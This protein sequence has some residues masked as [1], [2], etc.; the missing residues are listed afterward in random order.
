MEG[1]TCRDCDRRLLPHDGWHFVRFPLV[2]DPAVRVCEA[3]AV[4][5]AEGYKPDDEPFLIDGQDAAEWLRE[6]R[7]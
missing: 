6:S 3:C 2:T 5:R 1:V 7:G 4:E